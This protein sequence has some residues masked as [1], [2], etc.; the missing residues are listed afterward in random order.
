VAAASRK[1]ERGAT[2][3]ELL[4]VLAI[5][6]A[7]ASLWMP[8]LER[9]EERA[10]LRA[11]TRRVVTA[12][13]GAQARALAR[14]GSVTVRA[15]PARETIAIVEDDPEAPGEAGV[16]ISLERLGVDLGAVEPEGD[17]VF[18]LDGGPSSAK[19]YSLAAGGEVRHVVITAGTGHVREEP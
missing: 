13:R 12:L 15:D 5:V 19:R 6:A 8:R 4:A 7:A 16:E 10:L 14:H 2:L 11:D 18:S 1:S 9:V 17:L 3:V